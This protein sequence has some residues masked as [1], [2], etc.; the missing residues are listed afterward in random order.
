MPKAILS[1]WDE[2]LAHTRDA[3][4]ETME[5]VLKKYN[6]E[7]WT[8]IKTKY[9]DTA[10]SL[11]ENF[12]NFFAQDA[13]KAYR[14]YLEYYVK[15]AYNKVYPMENANDFLDFC[16]QKGIDLYII[17]NK[18]KSLLLKEVE[19]CFPEIVFKKILG[20][21]DAVLN[22]PSSAPV[23]KALDDVKYQINKDNVWLIGDSKQDSECAYNA[24]IQ[25][26]LFGEGK[27]TDEKYI[28]EKT[29]AR[30]PLLQFNNFNEIRAYLQ[31]N[32]KTA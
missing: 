9:R 29:N 18:E 32:K 6:K 5:Y 1:D 10:K 20:N 17:S 13:D 2:T 19:L 8:I 22:K 3:V 15:Y 27:F 7:P 30:I 4:V 16:S 24:N 31:K 25:P 14:E 11:K 12:P 23:F 28:K 26:I 21:G